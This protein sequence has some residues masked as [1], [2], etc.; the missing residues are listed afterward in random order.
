MLT[1]EQRDSLKNMALPRRIAEKKL[2]NASNKIEKTLSKY[3]DDLC[4]VISTEADK[5]L[6]Q[7]ESIKIVTYAEYDGRVFYLNEKADLLK[8]ILERN[9]ENTEQMSPLTFKSKCKDAEKL[10][11]W[12]RKVVMELS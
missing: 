11:V 10:I 4:V 3:D 8:W 7:D 12:Q 6:V 2:M 9:G 5:L 1:K